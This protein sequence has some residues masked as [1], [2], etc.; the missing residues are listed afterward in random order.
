MNTNGPRETTPVG[1][2]C[3]YWDGLD[4]ERYEILFKKNYA[5]VYFILN[6]KILLMSEFK[7]FYFLVYQMIS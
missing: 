5:L 3:F 4:S 2:V 1:R 6:E 7:P